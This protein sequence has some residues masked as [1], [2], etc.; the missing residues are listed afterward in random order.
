MMV[1]IQNKQTRQ[2]WGIDGWG[3]L[4]NAIRY[5]SKSVCPEMGE[6]IRRLIPSLT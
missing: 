4:A 1:V 3:N 6:K 2:F 5:E